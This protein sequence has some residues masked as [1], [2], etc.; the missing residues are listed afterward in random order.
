MAKHFPNRRYIRG[1]VNA[2]EAFGAMAAKAANSTPF[3]EAVTEQARISS[4]VAQYS[5]ENF[6]PTSGAGPIM[7]GVMHSDYTTTELE[8]FIENVSSWEE[9]N[10]VQ[11]KEIGRRLIRIVGTFPTP[12]SALVASV[13]NDGKPIK[14]KLNWPLSSGQTLRLWV[15]NLGTASV[16]TTTPIAQCRG[17]CNL[18]PQ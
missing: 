13:L 5:L 7:V 9:G 12:A 10:L 2:E 17:H 15:Y 16:A 3:P 1:V 6:T 18:W 4:I 14:T 11:S 8:E